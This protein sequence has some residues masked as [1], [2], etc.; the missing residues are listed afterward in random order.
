MAENAGDND[1]AIFPTEALKVAKLE[2]IWGK[3]PRRR[4]SGVG[5]DELQ[6]G[7]EPF[8]ILHANKLVSHDPGGLRSFDVLGKIIDVK[9]LSRW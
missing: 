4:Q 6:I 8:G 9:N 7:E 2:S 1:S 5:L 3:Y